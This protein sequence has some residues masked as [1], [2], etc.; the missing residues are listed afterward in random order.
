MLN[1]KRNGSSRAPMGTWR[2]EG[3][4]VTPRCAWLALNEI[5][6]NHSSAK[7]LECKNRCSVN[8]ESQV[9]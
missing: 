9:P 8:A 4:E 3:Q 7:G 5:I 6:Y 2:L 1:T